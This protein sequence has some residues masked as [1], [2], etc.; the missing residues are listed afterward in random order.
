MASSIDTYFADQGLPLLLEM[1]GVSITYTPAGGSAATVTALVGK[2]VSQEIEAIGQGDRTKKIT[3]SVTVAVAD[4]TG[5]IN[6]T[7]TIDS[8]QYEV[9]SITDAEAG[10]VTLSLVRDAAMEKARKQFRGH[11]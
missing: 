11:R 6:A 2:E 7:V 8:V 1:Q 9:D 5:G 3:R 10:Y 4:V